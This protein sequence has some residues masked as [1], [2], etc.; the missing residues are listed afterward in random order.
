MPVPPDD[1]YRKGDEVFVFYRM[2]KRCQPTRKYIATLDAKQGAYR[3]RI[4]MSEGW[5]P[6][7][8]SA[9]QDKN[10]HAGEVSIEYSWVHFYT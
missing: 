5:V 4:G 1:T 7:T 6:A 3:P 10:V 9:D 8:V 2:D